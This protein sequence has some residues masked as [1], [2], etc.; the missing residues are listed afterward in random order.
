MSP[1][2]SIGLSPPCDDH[3]NCAT[4]LTAVGLFVATGLALASGGGVSPGTEEDG[5][6]D[7]LGD[8]GAIALPQ[9]ATKS[10]SATNTIG[11]A[12]RVLLERCMVPS[13]LARP[14]ERS[15]EPV[16]RFMQNHPRS[17]LAGSIIGVDTLAYRVRSAF[18]LRRERR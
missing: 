13:L 7:P 1:G 14:I 15:A 10:T 4:E 17:E 18:R 8:G 12:L 11:A 3:T 16:D 9:A 5:A 2:K 6:S